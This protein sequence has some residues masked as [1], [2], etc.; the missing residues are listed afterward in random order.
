MTA[1]RIDALQYCNWSREIFEDWRAGG[2]DAVHV[3]VAYHEDFT[4]VV[5]RLKDWDTRFRDNADLILPGR[6][7]RDVRKAHSMGRT[8][9]FFGFQNPAPIGSDLGMLAICHRLGLRFM[10]LTYNLQSL[11]GA[12]WQEPEDTGLT[13]F[14]REV[15]AEMNRLGIIIDLSHA[16]ERTT[17]DAVEA[18][19]R[20]VAVTHANPRSWRETNRN[21]PETVMRALGESGGMLGFSLYPHHLA[22]GSDCALKAFCEMAARSAEIM[23][24]DRLGIGSDLC[25]GQPDS[26][27][28]WMRDGRWTF[29]TS[30]AVFPGQPTWFR[31]NR[32]WDG[33]VAGLRDVGFSQIEVD[34]IMGENWLR[35]WE[36][37]MRPAP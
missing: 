34:G 16:G 7:G 1:H 27:V 30:G 3:T 15:V 29:A 5:H 33:I 17:L 20:P 35:F 8:A 32:D 10:Q 24:A 31:S 26:V 21:L 9:V 6:S 12:G 13:R 37:G 11:C 19:G 18:S 36:D 25:Q 14:G 2:L 4:E 23:G 28:Q 22:D